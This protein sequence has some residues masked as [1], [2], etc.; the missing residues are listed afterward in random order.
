MGGGL[1]EECQRA[2]SWT[3]LGATAKQVERILRL[4]AKA[5]TIPSES[6]Q[7]VTVVSR[8]AHMDPQ[9]VFHIKEQAA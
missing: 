3:K 1:R 4:L 7:G 2:G 5:P 8:T 6:T 9:H